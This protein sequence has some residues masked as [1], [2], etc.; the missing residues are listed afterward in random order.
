MTAICQQ[1]AQNYSLYLANLKQNPAI[2]QFDKRARLSFL[3][4]DGLLLWRLVPG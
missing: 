3:N 2:S 4:W 1:D